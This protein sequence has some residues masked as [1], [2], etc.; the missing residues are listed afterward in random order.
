MQT[1]LGKPARVRV[2]LVD[3]DDRVRESLCGLLC[4]GERV[5][6]VGSTGHPDAAL[7]LVVETRPAI[8]VLDPRLP[9]LDGG[10]SFIDRLRATAPDVR[11]LVMS[12]ADAA[13][14]DD[15]SAVADGFIRKTFRPSDLVAA[16][17]AAT[18]PLVG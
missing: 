15:L 14:R 13:D 12:G 8:V 3:A 5:D 10:R 18:I 17:L 2:V 11:V 1:D 7:D 16:V 9:D 4:I 6:V